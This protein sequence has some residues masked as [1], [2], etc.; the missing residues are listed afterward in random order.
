[1]KILKIVLSSLFCLDLFGTI[2]GC[3]VLSHSSYSQEYWMYFVI[4]GQLFAVIGLVML[5]SFLHSERE[6]EG[7][8]ATGMIGQ[9]LGI[10][11]FLITGAGMI[12][13]GFLWRYGGEDRIQYIKMHAPVLVMIVTMGIACILLLF[14]FG[15]L[16]RVRRCSVKVDAVCT[17]I[18]AGRL[19]QSPQMMKGDG[20][21]NRKTWKL[22]YSFEYR[23]KKYTV[24]NRFNSTIG[25]KDG[26]T[27]GIHINPKNPKEFYDRVAMMLYAFLGFLSI[28]YIGITIYMLLHR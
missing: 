19:Y 25:L 22:Y 28:A 7:S 15:F 18:Q 1:M 14:C 17:G 21:G 24:S 6:I 10:V 4:I 3:L 11:L 16:G 9:W 27:Y 13:A 23:G 20:G 12:A 5:L 26:N 2:G 8:T